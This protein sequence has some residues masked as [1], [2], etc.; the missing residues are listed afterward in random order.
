MSLPPSLFWPSPTP[1]TSSVGWL[2]FTIFFLLSS[3]LSGDQK[4]EEILLLSTAVSDLLLSEYLLEQENTQELNPLMKER[5]QRLTLKSSSAV[6][7]L[8]LS[9]KLQPE[10][11]KM[12]S[13]LRWTSVA[14]WG[15]ATGFN[16]YV[17]VKVSP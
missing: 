10:H 14:F 8:Y 7:V 1:G 17:A 2:L 15:G 4:K 11:P 16:V 9:R 12:A 13:L 6:L 5:W 3:P